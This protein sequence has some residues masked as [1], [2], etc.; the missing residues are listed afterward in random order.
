MNREWRRVKKKKKESDLLP[1]TGGQGQ[2]TM[3]C[4]QA[5]TVMPVM[6]QIITHTKKTVTRPLNM[7]GT[8]NSLNHK[9]KEE[10]NE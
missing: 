5:C 2:I 7:M 1:I 6:I 3:E 9:N 8:V 10:M 4:I